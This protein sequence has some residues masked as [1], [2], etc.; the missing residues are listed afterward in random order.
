MIIDHV[1]NPSASLRSMI[2]E[3]AKVPLLAQPGTRWSYSIGIDVQ[4]YLVE[5]M[6]G[7]PFAVFLRTWIF[8]PLGMKDT[9]FYVPRQAMSR[10]SEVHIGVGSAMALDDRPDPTV[11]PLGPSETR[12]GT[13][14][15]HRTRDATS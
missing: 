6:S 8:E 12:W 1:L 5:Q 10:F 15:A 13:G 3:L 14:G 2:D 7:Q 11:V 9:A 4:G